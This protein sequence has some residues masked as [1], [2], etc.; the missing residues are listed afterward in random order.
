[1]YVKPVK[2]DDGQS[3]DGSNTEESGKDAVELTDCV[4]DDPGVMHEREHGR[5][6]VESG[7]EQVAA[8]QVEYQPIVGRRQQRRRHDDDPAD[9][10]VADDCHCSR[11]R[12]PRQ[13]RLV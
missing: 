4:A 2:R 3:H 13:R 12:H 5:R 9:S 1:M 11:R 8:G 10:D 7:R 6:T